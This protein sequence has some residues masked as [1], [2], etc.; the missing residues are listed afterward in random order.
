MALMQGQ[1]IEPCRVLGR[2]VSSG[3]GHRLFDVDVAGELKH[4][5]DGPVGSLRHPEPLN[6][7][8]E[9]QA[10]ARRQLADDVLGEARAHRDNRG[11][12]RIIE[13]LGFTWLNDY[14]TEIGVFRRYR[15]RA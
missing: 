5:E 1:N 4:I 14:Q 3:S 11:S 2:S 7:I 10:L 9:G 15:E 8:D 13:K 6:G 12:L